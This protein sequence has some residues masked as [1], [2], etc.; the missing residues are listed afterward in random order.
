VSHQNDWIALR[1]SGVSTV[2]IA[3]QSGVSIWRVYDHFKRA[4][5]R[6]PDVAVARELSELEKAWIAAVI[7]CE[8]CISARQV[9]NKQRECT[10]IQYSVRVEMTTNQIPLRLEAI[11]GGKY[12]DY[13]EQKG[14]RK[15][16]CMWYATPRVLRWL[17]PA[18]RNHLMVKQR[19]A[20]IVIDLLAGRRRG[21]R[22]P[23]FNGRSN[24]L[25]RELTSINIKGRRA[26][27]INLPIADVIC[28]ERA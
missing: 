12:L 8:G 23:E 14:N 7:D 21:I 1:Q 15:P 5:F 6:R 13:F 27:I 2:E 3:A 20:D 9:P 22:N 24:D 11:C 17:L 18:I 25:L 4:G 26:Q 28:M 16:H 10:Q 19:H